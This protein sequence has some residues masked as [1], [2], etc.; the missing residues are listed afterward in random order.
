MFDEEYSKLKYFIQKNTCVRVT[1]T[2][3]EQILPKKEVPTLV[4]MGEWANLLVDNHEITVE[5]E[6]KMSSKTVGEHLN[7][8]CNINGL[9]WEVD[10]H[11][12][13]IIIISHKW[14]D[15]EQTNEGL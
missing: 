11:D 5:A 7:E 12:D 4:E 3:L 6:L 15:T 2:L 9:T 10:L 13:D 14:P 8:F 1:I